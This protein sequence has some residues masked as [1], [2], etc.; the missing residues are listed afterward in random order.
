MNNKHQI[1]SRGTMHRECKSSLIIMKSYGTK[2]GR[3]RGERT[4]WSHTFKPIHFLEWPM[5][6]TEMDI[7]LRAQKG[8]Q[9]ALVNQ[10]NGGQS[11]KVGCA[12]SLQ[13][14][15]EYQE[16]SLYPECFF[17]WL[18]CWPKYHVIFI[19]LFN[20]FMLHFPVSN[21]GMLIYATKSDWRANV[22]IN[23]PWSLVCLFQFCLWFGKG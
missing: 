23:N 12:W 19:I 15:N 6:C 2:K 16:E 8:K 21:M 13:E 22:R 7:W 14:G 9:A 20:L 17:P 10:K 1:Q 3:L 11:R 5:S 4:I 18:L